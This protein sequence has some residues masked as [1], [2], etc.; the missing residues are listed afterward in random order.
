MASNEIKIILL[1][2]VGNA[3]RTGNFNQYAITLSF[4]QAC[5]LLQQFHPPSNSVA[6]NTRKLRLISGFR[7]A[8]DEI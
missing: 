6:E 4:V 5:Y 8:A 2:N 7:P 1:L 3:R